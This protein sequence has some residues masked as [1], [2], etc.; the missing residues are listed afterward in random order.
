MMMKNVASKSNLNLYEDIIRFMKV[1][2]IIWQSDLAKYV[3]YKCVYL[4]PTEW[5]GGGE[6][7]SVAVL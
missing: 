3:L 1:M 6:T 5:V 2:E 7:S 4:F